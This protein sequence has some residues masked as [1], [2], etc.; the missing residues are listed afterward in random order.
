MLK[1]Q[2]TLCDP[3]VVSGGE[4]LNCFTSCPSQGAAFAAESVG[5]QHVS[6]GKLGY[7]VPCYPRLPRMFPCLHLLCCWPPFTFSS[8]SLPGPC[9]MCSAVPRTGHIPRA[10][11]EGSEHMWSHGWAFSASAHDFQLLCSGCCSC[12]SRLNIF[13][14]WE[15]A[16]HPRKI[17]LTVQWPENCSLIK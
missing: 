16:Q 8:A 12:V 14:N 5:K 15:T 3:V 1:F 13:R 4:G 2:H 17:Q 7:W 10:V 9:G 11:W 6:F